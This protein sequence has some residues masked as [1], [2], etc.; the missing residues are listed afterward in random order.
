MRLSFKVVVLAFFALFSSLTLQA[1]ETRGFLTRDEIALFYKQGY[2][3]KRQC[4]SQTEMKQLNADITTVIDRAIDEIQHSKDLTFSDEDQFLYI[5]GSRIVCKRRPDQS[6]SI[7]RVNGCGGM[8][9]SLLNTM[10]SE[11][12]VRTFFELLG[13]DDLEHLISQI[14]PK[15]PGDGVAYPRHRDIQF[16]KSFDPDWQD[17]L[18]NGS[19]AICIIPIDRMAP[20]NGGL[21]IDKN[22]YPE[23]QG[24]AEDIVWLYAEPGDLLF[25]HPYLYHG[26]G[27]NLAP[28]SSRKMLLT[29]FCAFGANHKPYPGAHVNT[30]FTLTREG[31]ISMTAAP[32]SQGVSLGSG[33]GH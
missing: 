15:L 20:E 25:M 5:D 31:K 1:V 14:H 23:P 2:L 8:Q 10:R 24:L 26:S 28:H 6:I 16:R 4:L 33:V 11:K 21:W 29:G 3:L 32:W 18:G 9:P 7:A 12:M 30:R 22:N 27:P 19:Y 13:T 17:V